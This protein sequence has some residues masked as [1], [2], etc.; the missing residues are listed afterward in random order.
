[1]RFFTHFIRMK[2][3][4]HHYSIHVKCHSFVKVLN[5][6]QGYPLLCAEG[7]MILRTSV[8]GG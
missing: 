3:L 6:L 7:C 2:S 8:Y 1:M 4:L 5:F